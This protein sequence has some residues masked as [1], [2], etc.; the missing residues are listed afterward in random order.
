MDFLLH[1]F[2]LLITVFSL[3]HLMTLGLFAEYSRKH[4]PWHKELFLILGS[5]LYRELHKLR[6]SLKAQTILNL[7]HKTFSFTVMVTFNNNNNKPLQLVSLLKI[8]LFT[9]PLISFQMEKFPMDLCSLHKRFLD[10]PSQQL[11]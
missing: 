9:C 5:L 2:M 7:V 4:T 1:Y 10:K 6:C 11:T 8:Y 3:N